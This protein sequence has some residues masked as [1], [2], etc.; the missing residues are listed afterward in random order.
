M[1]PARNPARENIREQPPLAG[2]VIAAIAAPVCSRATAASE[3]FGS[4]PRHR[5]EQARPTG[6]RSP[7]RSNAAAH[8]LRLTRPR[9]VRIIPARG[10]PRWPREAPAQASRP[11]FRQRVDAN[12]RLQ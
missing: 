9:A 1:N 3:A 12:A 8:R 5:R 6:E 10:C 11:R 2:A 7:N 4:A